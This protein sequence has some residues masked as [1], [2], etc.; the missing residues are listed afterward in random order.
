VADAAVLKATTIGPQ[1]VMG[2]GTPP[3]SDDNNWSKLTPY[4]AP[5]GNPN[6]ATLVTSCPWVNSADAAYA[7]ANPGYYFQQASFAASQALNSDLSVTID[8]PWVVDSPT[9]QGLDGNNRSRNVVNQDAGGVV[10]QFKYTPKPGDPANVRFIQAYNQS[11]NGGAYQIFLDR[12]SSPT[13]FYDARG[14]SGTAANGRQLANNVSWM[15]DTPYDTEAQLDRLA[16][17]QEG[18]NEKDT[19]SDVQ[20]QVLLAVDSGPGM[21]NGKRYTDIVTTYG[22]FWWGY[23]YWNSD[24]PGRQEPDPYTTEPFNTAGEPVSIYEDSYTPDVGVAPD[25]CPTVFLTGCSLLG[26]LALRRCR[27]FGGVCQQAG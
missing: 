4:T 17:I 14:V 12:G 20:F 9:V 16:G 27:A 19:S 22:G 5:P 3:Q 25:A 1:Q 11:L 8:T 10:F 24:L 26:L 15:Q 6:G 21:V 2:T 18:P 7:A 13:P 23:N